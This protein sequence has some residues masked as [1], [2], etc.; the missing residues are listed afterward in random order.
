MPYFIMGD[1]SD[2]IE[3]GNY[4]YNNGNFQE[5]IDAYSKAIE[6]DPCYGVSYL[7]R[8]LAY[9]KQK[10]Y[11]KAIIDFTHIF[12]LKDSYLYAEAYVYR[13]RVLYKIKEYDKAISDC[14]SAIKIDPSFE[15]SF[16]ILGTIYQEIGKDKESI[17]C[18]S[19]AIL[20]DSENNLAFMFRGDIY[21]KLGRYKNAIS[22]YKAVLELDPKNEY[23]KKSLAETLGEILDDNDFEE[24]ATTDIE[25][26]T[27]TEDNVKSLDEYIMELNELIGLKRVKDEVNTIIN[28]L[29][30]KKL[31]ESKGLKQASMSLHLVFSGNPGT[32]KTTI[33]RI[34]G[35]IYRAL[36]VLSKGHLIEVD[37]A[38][39]VA[40]YIGQTAIKTTEVIA[41]AMG[42][43][44]F[45]DEAYSL[46]ENGSDND[47]G[48][49]A[50]D[51]LLKAMED[52]RDD[53]IVIVA[54]YPEPMSNFLKSNPG[55]QSRFNTFI[56]FDDYSANELFD[57]FLGLCK[58]YSYTISDEAKE[59]LCEYFVILYNNKQDNFANARE[60]RNFFENTMKKQ[61]NR[62]VLDNDI[63][64]DEL[65]E[66]TLGDLKF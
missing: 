32:G 53:F 18:F 48:N 57:I 10:D 36:G 14:K 60:V 46:T 52:H 43:I 62:L 65:L 58:K 40:G 45:I 15:E 41:K 35:N 7:N 1:K 63:T 59:Y 47:Y 44:L 16:I 38:G 50:V 61:A 29:K 2:Y 33:A 51:T 64:D 26:N 54:G 21:K 37:R 30:V 11:S 6:S 49:E 12:S 39:L 8:G 13:A 17:Q 34:L 4:Y 42:G 27:E 66:I 20:L 56:H 3:N 19:K 25:Y 24:Q 23:V 5:A 55:L 28:L 22:D 31:R 9:E